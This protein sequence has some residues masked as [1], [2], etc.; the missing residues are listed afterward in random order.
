MAEDRKPCHVDTGN[1]GQDFETP[2]RT[3]TVLRTVAFV[4]R[5]VIG[6]YMGVVR[7]DAYESPVHEHSGVT[8]AEDV[9]GAGLAVTNEHGRE[10]PAARWNSNDAGHLSI[11]C[12]ISEGISRDGQTGQSSL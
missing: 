3:T 5:R 6:G 7:P 12:V 8:Q 11:R 1:V 10:R 9:G 4:I 2:P